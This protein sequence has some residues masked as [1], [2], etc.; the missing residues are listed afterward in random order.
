M[1][2]LPASKWADLF[3]QACRIIDQA[4]SSLT[5]IDTWT[6]GGGTALMLQIDHRE[7]FDVDIFLDDPQ[8]LP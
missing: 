7:S 4:N 8:L 2:D 1:D 3:D 5:L 6:F